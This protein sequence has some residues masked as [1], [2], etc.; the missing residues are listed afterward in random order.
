[1][2]E[3]PLHYARNRRPESGGESVL[4]SLVS[5][6]LFLYVGFVLGLQGISESAVY[7]G[8][9]AALT[10]GARIVGIGLLVTTAL[11]YF[12]VPGAAILDLLL[13]ALATGGCLVIGVIWIFF[14]DMQGVLL[15]LFGALNGSA[16]RAAWIRWQ[17]RPIASRGAGETQDRD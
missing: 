11:T 6:G 7:N 5:A 16:T 14:S 4:L 2:S 15:L 12:R 8:S 9:V 10:W 13:A 3:P 17:N 1:M